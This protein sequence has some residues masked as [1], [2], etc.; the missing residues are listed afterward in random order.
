MTTQQ[1]PIAEFQ[2]IDRE[3][4]QIITESGEKYKLGLSVERGS[5]KGAEIGREC[6]LTNIRAAV[7][8]G[9]S[10]GLTMKLVIKFGEK[11]AEADSNNNNNIKLVK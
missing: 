3:T 4:W 5:R 8:L 9:Q 11:S 6:K 1:W 2:W 7:S 10:S